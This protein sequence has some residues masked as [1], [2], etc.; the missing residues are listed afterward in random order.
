MLPGEE[1]PVTSSSERT[2]IR[3]AGQVAVVTG[4]GSGIGAAVSR[5]LA[6]EGAR[7]HVVDIDA[8][9]AEA[10]A[11]EIGGVAHQV[12]VS[13]LAAVDGL[14]TDVAARRGSLDVVVHS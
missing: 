7:V 12:D 14:V 10:V 8:A 4:G 5:R 13:D 3:F 1:T 6:Q 2:G 11:D 9:A